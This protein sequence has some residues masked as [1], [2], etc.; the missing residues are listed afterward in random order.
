MKKK[1]SVL[2]EAI[3]GFLA[4]A[5]S[6]EALKPVGAPFGVYQQRSGDF[7]VRVR[8]NGG[9][10]AC[11]RFA[12][13]AGILDA[14]GGHAHLTSRQDIQLHDIPAARVIDAMAASD[15]LGL[16]FKGGGGNTYRNTLVG[17]DSGLSAESAFD[18]YPYAH[19]LNRAMQGVEKAFAL[20]RKLKI[21]FFASERDRLRA[22]VQ[23]LGFLA[24]VRDGVEGFTVY[25][26]GGM[27]RESAAGLELI[28]FLPGTQIV[29]A[30][31]ALTELFYDHGDRANRQQARLRF[32]L[33]RLGAE[34]FQRLFLEYFARTD[35]PLVHVRAHHSFEHLVAGLKRGRATKP[36]EGFALWEQ[37]AVAPTRFGDDVKSVRLFVPYGNLNAA[38]LR[39]IAALA[40][41]YGS[42]TVRLLP[43]QDIL[44]PLVH[45]SALGGLYKRLRQELGDID[46]TFASYKGHLV[47]CV[48]A[49]VCK[50]GM[51]DTPA[52]ADAVAAELDRHLP[53]D[54]PEKLR[55]LKVIADDVRIS[56]CPNSCAGHPAARIG[57]ECVK[58]RVG[59]EVKTF[60]TLFTGAGVRADGKVR[61]SERQPGEPVPVEQLARKL[62]EAA[63][64]LA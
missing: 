46:L 15:H 48:G 49:S 38:Q 8:I 28:G 35:A 17:T 43:A 22:A 25:V 23:D 2:K 32:L 9:E 50:I 18:V 40:A 41:E 42:P 31:V 51:A 64:D 19:A 52:V 21:G 39:K 47:T 13:I 33:K 36:A 37:Y 34:A 24:R 29:R 16:P 20:P 26:A 56:G 3:D 55:L 53:P 60:A 61:L 30:A 11:E 62:L 5:V 7:M 12:G 57:V 27:G 45:R 14:C 6:S 63:D 54:T 1:Y 10:I 44:I 58:R 4:G 59:E